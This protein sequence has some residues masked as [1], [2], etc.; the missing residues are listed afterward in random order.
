MN[1]FDSYYHAA[2]HLN[3][4]DR[5]AFYDQLFAF[6]YEG[7]EGEITGTAAA[8]WEAV[9]PV[10]AKSRAKSGARKGKTKQNQN[11]I[12]QK[13]NEKQNDN[14]TKSNQKQIENHMD[15][16]MEK[17]MD[18]NPPISPQGEDEVA[19]VVDYMNEVCGT[20]YRATSDA[21]RKHI[22]ARLDDG[23]TVDDCKRVI[24]NK[25]RDWIGTDYAKY[26]RPGTLFI[27]SKFEAYLNQQGSREIDWSE[28]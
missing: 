16:D 3:D 20:N 5:H 25:A 26:L 19:I 10:V 17:D 22:K 24:D 12:K 28:L 9:K 6:Y 13:S 23:F 27:P 21:T 18:N 8:V 7:I 14:K 4:V 1:F 2:K 15:M 11:E